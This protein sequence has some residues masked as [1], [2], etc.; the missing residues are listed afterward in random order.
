M[1][2]QGA[3]T[4]VAA[5]LLLVA[6][7][8]ERVV[9]LPAPDGHR[10]AV[11]VRDQNRELLLDKPYAAVV[12]RAGENDTY[13]SSPEEVT[14]HFAAA[15]AAQPP[16]PRAYILYFEPGGELLTPASKAE[17]DKIRGEIAKREASEVMV[18]GHTDRVGSLQSNDE[19]SKKRADSIR[20][21]LIQSG[22]PA[23]KL[24]AVGRGERDPLVATEDEVEE[25]KNR[26]VEISLR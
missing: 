12:R 26:R 1:S 14:E 9:L 11:I 20:E 15:L 2:R 25:P 5:C 13:Q 7:A 24:E 23:D 8:S 21:L 4:G 10:S 6:C 16:R 3:L 22:V 17:F 19:L 18:I